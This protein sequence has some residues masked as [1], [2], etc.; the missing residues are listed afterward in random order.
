LPEILRAPGRVSALFVLGILILVRVRNPGFVQTFALHGFDRQQQ[1]AP[2][3]Y[4]PLPVAIVAIDDRSLSRYGQWPWPRTLLGRLVRQIASGQPRVIGV[5]IIFAEP[6]RMSPGRLIDTRPD[7]P[8]ALAHELALLP[9]NELALA[10]ALKGVP[11]V[12][13]IG[14]SDEAEPASRGPSR[15]PIIRESGGNPRPFLATYPYFLRSV[16]ELIA[17]ARGQGAVLDNP[18]AD[19]ITRRMPLFVVGQGQLTLPV[20]D[21]LPPPRTILPYA[22]PEERIP[23]G[24][25]PCYGMGRSI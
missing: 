9:P 21:A 8:V 19:G 2:R 22:G 20:I 14:A 13:G 25:T 18:D 4:R 16:P 3:A 15:V 23:R 17:S 5:D 7:L 12:L 1:I 11:A 24:W 6:D 10:E